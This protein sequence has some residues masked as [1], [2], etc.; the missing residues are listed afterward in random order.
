[1]IA[2]GVPHVDACV[3]GAACLSKHSRFNYLIELK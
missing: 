2:D 3:D 1:M